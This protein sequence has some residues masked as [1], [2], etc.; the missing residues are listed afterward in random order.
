MNRTI[1][2]AGLLAFISGLMVLG[3]W[4]GTSL[5]FSTPFPETRYR[6]MS[7][8][9][10]FSLAPA[11]PAA[12]AAATPGFAAQ[13]F[14][15]GVA[16]IGQT[17]FVAI[18]SR[19]PAQAAPIFLEVGESTGDGMKVERVK[20]SDE[21]G[22][23]TVD[24]TKGGEKA[25]LVFDEAQLAT[26][27]I[28]TQPGQPEIPPPDAPLNRYQSNRDNVQPYRFPLEPW[29]HANRQLNPDVL[30]GAVPRSQ[31]RNGRRIMSGQ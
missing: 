22:R 27:S 29:L 31:A 17:D 10:P 6:Q 9:S 23:S 24:V 16:H 12:A 2:R 1:S 30:Q 21:M 7:A 5:P 26:N 3:A 13:L 15:D 19:D 20:W 28:A 14:V 18:K 8:K 4:A 25:T 11:A